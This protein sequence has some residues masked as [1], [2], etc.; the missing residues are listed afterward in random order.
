[1]HQ[2]RP[3]PEVAS[4]RARLAGLTAR[5]AD[6]ETIAAARAELVTV[7][8]SARATAKAR[9]LATL[10]VGDR[11]RLATLILAGGGGDVTA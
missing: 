2:K 7:T 5:R 9:E 4:A 8:A 10:P 11:V 1:M 6:P 3:S